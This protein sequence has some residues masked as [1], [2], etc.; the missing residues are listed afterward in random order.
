MC[1][2]IGSLPIPLNECVA[3]PPTTNAR[4]ELACL[5]H[6]TIM[7]CSQYEGLRTEISLVIQY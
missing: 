1:V 2:F 4:S 6:V 7:C 5:F 3:L